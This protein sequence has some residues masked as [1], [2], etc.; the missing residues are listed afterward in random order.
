MFEDI[1]AEYIRFELK[2]KNPSLAKK[3]M[4]ESFAYVNEEHKEAMLDVVKKIN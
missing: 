3:L 4:T 1:W 2:S